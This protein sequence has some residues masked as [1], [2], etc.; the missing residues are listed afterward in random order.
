MSGCGSWAKAPTA[1]QSWC[2]MAPSSASTAWLKGLQELLAR[3]RWR[4]LGAP[5]YVAKEIRIGHL[6]EKERSLAL[7][8]AQVL[9]RL[10][11]ANIIRYV[12]S[13]VEKTLL[14]I[15]MEY[16]DNGDLATQIQLRRD[17]GAH[18][19]ESEV[20]QIHVQ[21]ALALSHIHSMKILHRDLRL[22]SEIYS[23]SM[24]P[25]SP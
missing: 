14:Y 4:F 20:M 15:I 13:W 1:P 11:H 12:E 10:Q 7:S 16:A 24:S 6:G 8:E 22:G 2:E 25:G 17:A 21:L 23:D 18:F 9:R 19:T 3:S 5:R